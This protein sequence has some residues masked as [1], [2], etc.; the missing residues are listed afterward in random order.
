[1]FF[2]VIYFSILKF[3]NYFIERKLKRQMRQMLR[4][5]SLT[6]RRLCSVTKLFK[7]S[8]EEQYIDS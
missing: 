1:M 3:L 4:I 7:N 8:I 2:E 6:D 5:V